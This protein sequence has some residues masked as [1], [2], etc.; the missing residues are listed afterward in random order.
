MRPIILFKEAII[1]KSFRPIRRSKMP[2]AVRRTSIGVEPSYQ[3][4][5][6]LEVRLSKIP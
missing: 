5:D 1:K 4:L 3:V 6:I 2:H